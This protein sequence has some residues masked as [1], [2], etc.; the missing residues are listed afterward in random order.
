MK[1]AALL[2]GGVDSS[3]ALSL[4]KNQGHKDITAFYL[5]IWLEDE[6]SHLGDCPWEEDLTYAKSVCDALDVPLEVVSL[7]GEYWER[8][9]SYAIAELKA[10]RTPSPDVFCNQK[11]KFGAFTERVGHGF[12]KIIS[13]HYASVEESDGFFR[14]RKGKDP[15]KD[16]AYFLSHL[17]QAQLARC[18]FPLGNYIKSEI[19]ALAHQFNLATKDRPDSQ[20]ICFLGKIPYNEFVKFHLGVAKGDIRELETD[21]VLG[22]HQGFWFHTIGQRKGLGLSGGPWFVVKK[23]ITKNIVYVSHEEHVLDTERDQFSVG[24]LHWI[25][26]APRKSKL[27]VKLRHG[28]NS[29]DCELNAAAGSQ[30]MQVTLGSKDRGVAPGQ[31]AVFYDGDYCLGSGVIV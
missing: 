27:Q 17:D 11:I 14:L 8:V 25:A 3:V 21:K 30:L 5:K 1:I 16:Q 13:G 26:D 24:D 2:S 15:I 22:S 18:E 19:R 20:G 9:V 28:A 12:D 31:F 4:M 6:L 7:Q 29:Y 23:D 10:G